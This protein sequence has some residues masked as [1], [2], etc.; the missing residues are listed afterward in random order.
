MTRREWI[1][2]ASE[3]SGAPTIDGCLVLIEQ[4]CE[5]TAT[6]FRWTYQETLAQPAWLVWRL[7]RSDIARMIEQQRNR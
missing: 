3:P 5:F 6:R 7:W 1:P 2:A 4:V